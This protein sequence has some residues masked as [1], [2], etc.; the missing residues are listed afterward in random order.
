MAHE[1]AK[2][3]QTGGHAFVSGNNIP[4]WH[5]LGTVL[6]GFLTAEECLKFGG[7]N[8]QVKKRIMT[9]EMPS[10]DGNGTEKIVVPNQYA[11]VRTDTN[12]VLG[13]VGKN[14]TVVQNEEAFTFFDEITGGG[15]A[16]YETAG[17]LGI[18][19]R[20]FISAKMPNYVSIDG[21]DDPTEM[22]VLLTSSH[23]GQG[24][25][26]AII[27]P[28]RV[29]CANTLSFALQNNVN[30]VR[31]SHTRTAKE[32]LAEA[33]KVLGITN[34]YAEEMNEL[35][36]HMNS[37]KVSDDQAKDIINQLFPAS[38]EEN[39]HATTQKSRDLLWKGYTEGVG[40]EKIIGTGYGLMQGVTYFTSHLKDY[41]DDSVQLASIIEGQAAKF[42]SQAKKLILAL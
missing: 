20:I 40:Q 31:I 8:Y 28:I 7:L 6:E 13:V 1:I 9:T 36:N 29:V 26:K 3:I 42:N 2:N 37:I 10:L 30:C 35:L 39:V 4:A 23:D 32:R 5:R 22:Y 34:R 11:T 18:G 27:T 21:V 14:Y 12:Q 19:E 25:I 33:S 38:D 16:I 24:S 15:E 17:A 41:K